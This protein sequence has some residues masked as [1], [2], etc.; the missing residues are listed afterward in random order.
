MYGTLEKGFLNYEQWLPAKP[1]PEF[2]E[3]HFLGWADYPYPLPLERI[4]QWEVLP[5]D[6]EQY[7]KYMFWRETNKN[8]DGAKAYLDYYLN[9]P[10]EKLLEI[11]KEKADDLAPLALEYKQ[12]GW[13]WWP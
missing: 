9:L 3:R 11:V 12:A 10:D 1:A 5:A 6:R 2:P 8:Y 4:W 13:R 7:I